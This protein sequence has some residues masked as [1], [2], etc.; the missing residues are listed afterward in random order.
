MQRET[1]R[2]S[3]TII[4]FLG[5]APT[6]DVDEARVLECFSGTIE[7][8]MGICKY[9]CVCLDLN[10][11]VELNVFLTLAE[12]FCLSCSSCST[13]T[14]CATRI[15]GDYSVTALGSILRAC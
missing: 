10:T 15:G 12:Q 8:K 3:R 13:L 11:N 14:L 5:C 4:C 6:Q 1:Q 7:I 2:A 9:V